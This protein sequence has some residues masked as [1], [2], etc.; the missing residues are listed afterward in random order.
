[1]DSNEI[2]YLGI[3]ILSRADEVNEVRA[4]S[5][6]SIVADMALVAAASYLVTG[7]LP[8]QRSQIDSTARL[9]RAL[10]YCR[11]PHGIR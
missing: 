5:V 7:P 11:H 1:M 8:W 2:E 4:A 10:I 6:S 3:E 9:E